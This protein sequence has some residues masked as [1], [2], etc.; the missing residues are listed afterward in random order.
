MLISGLAVGS[1]G[2]TDTRVPVEAAEFTRE[3]FE[4]GLLRALGA[5]DY[6]GSM[7]VLR[8]R[9]TILAPTEHELR[10][11]VDA[12]P[13][14]DVDVPGW[15][16]DDYSMATATLASRAG[17]TAGVVSNHDANPPHAYN[18]VVTQSGGFWWLEPQTGEL[19]EVG[20]GESGIVDDYDP[21]PGA[22]A[23]IWC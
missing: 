14:P 3:Q 2:G 6:L 5:G 4:Q 17:F 1:V 19:Y 13:W 21:A 20:E 11:F 8:P 12:L 23:F 7:P 16:C 9:D 10:L 22:N 18:V 15:D